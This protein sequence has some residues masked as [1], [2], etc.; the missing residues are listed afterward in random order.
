M[1]FAFVL[2][3]AAYVPRNRIKAAVKHPMIVGVKIWAA[4]HLL[5][6]GTAADLLLFGGFLVWAVASFR[7][8]RARDR[9]QASAPTSVTLG[10]TVATLVFGAVAWAVFALYLHAWLFGVQP[11]VR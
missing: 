2:L 1:L 9:L 10:G 7:A 6:N 8:A 5:A 3:V 4:G 11:F